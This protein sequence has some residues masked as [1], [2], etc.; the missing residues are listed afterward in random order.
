MLLKY[1][2][3]P[4][5]EIKLGPYHHGA[6]VET[7]QSIKQFED[8]MKNAGDKVVV[9]AFVND[10]GHCRDAEVSMDRFKNQ[11]KEIRFYK[12]NTKQ[13]EELKNRYADGNSK[14]YFKFYK[15]GEL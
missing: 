7:I 6:K 8:A 12:V 9:V 4:V 1:N 3:G 2:E 5:A 13:S 15:G 14:P 10:Q 11:Y